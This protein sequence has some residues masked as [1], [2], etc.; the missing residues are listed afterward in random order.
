[1]EGE[2]IYNPIIIP[3]TITDRRSNENY[4]NDYAQE[5]GG[6]VENGPDIVYGFALPLKDVWYTISV[7]IIASDFDPAIYIYGGPG[8]DNTGVGVPEHLEYRYSPYWS[9]PICII[10]D[11]MS[12]DDDFI[13]TYTLTVSHALITPTPTPTPTETPSPTPTPI[14]PPYTFNFD[15]G[16]DGWVF[17]G[18]I[19]PFDPPAQTSAGGHLGLSPAGLS[20]CFGFW[21]SPEIQVQN[22]VTYR[23]AF[24]LTSS[25]STG[26]LVPACR[27]RVNQRNFYGSTARYIISGGDGG[28]APITTPRSY[29]VLFT[30]LLSTNDG[31]VTLSFDIC[32]FGP[33]DDANAWIYLESV[34]I[35]EVS[36]SP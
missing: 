22:G 23:A 8:S 18:K 36:V 29:N 9:G 6:R 32:N 28:G 1:L 33:F 26:E 24:S 10:V 15:T 5:V 11:S 31:A 7:D 16:A 13:G 35:E 4:H 14:S 27:L 34:T 12:F 3:G 20:F 30:P 17:S 21:D 19:G 2:T 25:L